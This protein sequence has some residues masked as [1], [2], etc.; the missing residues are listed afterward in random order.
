MPP[1]TALATT[2]SLDDDLGL[3]FPL[4]PANE[5]WLNAQGTARTGKGQLQQWTRAFGEALAALRRS[6]QDADQNAGA[7]AHVLGTY[8]RQFRGCSAWETLGYVG[9]EALCTEHLGISDRHARRLVFFAAIT[10]KEEAA[11]GLRKCLAGFALAGALG[12]DGLGALVPTGHGWKE[13]AEWAARIGEPVAFLDSTAARLE[14]LLTLATKPALPAE[15]SRKVAAVVETRRKLIDR[16]AARHPALEALAVRS[17]AHGGVARISNKSASTP[18]E[19]LA[20]RALF[21]ALA[22][23]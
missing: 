5:S 22:K 12:A 18:E 11:F 10:T 2:S 1:A 15:P 16:V 20:L 21:D 17:Y 3:D 6:E 4:P 19:F 9:F 23:A 7:L 13:P 14:R 8:L